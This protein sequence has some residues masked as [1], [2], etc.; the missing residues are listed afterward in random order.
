MKKKLSKEIKIP[1]GTEVTIEENVIKAKGLEG[2]N[3]KK[4]D[5]KKL[6]IKKEEDKIILSHDNAT[7]KEKKIMNTLASHIKN[8][9]RG[10]N[11]KFKYKLKI[12]FIHFP[13]TVKIE[14]GAAIIKNFLGE[15]IERKVMLPKNVDIEINK[16]IITI[17]SVDK[18]LA[19][20]AAANL[21]TVTKIRNRDKR[22]FQDGIYIINKDGKEM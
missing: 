21:E 15:K 17:K 14:K 20:Q 6:N 18:E 7:K 10:V 19:G 4:F 8:L 2:E 22:I 1:E 11:L 9:F 3:S 12:C 16:E 5:F 13:F